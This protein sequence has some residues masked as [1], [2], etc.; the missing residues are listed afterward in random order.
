MQLNP[1]KLFA[2]GRIKVKGN[3]DRALD[4]EKILTH[5][6]RKLEGAIPPFS[7]LPKTR[8]EGRWFAVRSKL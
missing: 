2:G 1:Q 4:A 3:I 8:R 6:R 5:E 7:K